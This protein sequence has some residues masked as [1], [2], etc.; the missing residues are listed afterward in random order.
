MRRILVAT[1][2]AALWTPAVA[3]AQMTAPVVGNF[4]GGA[5]TTPP[6]SPFAAGSMVVGLRATGAATIRVSATIVAR[7]ASASF[8]ATP[9][10]AADGS[11]VATGAVRQGNVRM[12]YELHGTLSATPSGTATASM[13]RTV[14]G[15][16]RRCSARGVAWEVRRPFGGFG[17][18]AAAAPG[19]LLLGIT[20]Q[21]QRGVRRGIAL[22]VSPDGRALSRAIYG[23]TLRCTGDVRSVTFDLPRDDLA[24]A[25]D[26]RVSDREST[27]RRT[28]ATIV[29]SVE[30]FGATVGSDGAEGFLSA[31]LTVRRRS[32]GRRISRCRS[33]TVRW[34]ASY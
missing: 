13:R 3:A 9:A 20:G 17:V 15:R 16:T 27:S 25:P 11:F 10:V 26:G 31:T 18:P 21:R 30:R 28:K 6:A 5:V 14:G 32:T 24:I 1:L 33:G 12:S 2:T 29:S 22:R 19:G 23:V 8:S 34:S 4:G 7:C